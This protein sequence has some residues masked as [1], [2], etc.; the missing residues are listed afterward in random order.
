MEGIIVTE[1]QAI[2]QGTTI[3]ALVKEYT[4]KG[5]RVVGTMQHPAVGKIVKLAK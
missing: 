5:Y 3:E 2:G 4:D 1:D